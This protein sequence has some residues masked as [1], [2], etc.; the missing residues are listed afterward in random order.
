MATTISSSSF[1][2]LGQDLRYGLRLL[3]RD[4]G[5]TLIAVL[6]IALGVGA[7]TT[8]FSVT[9]SLLLKPLP[10]PDADRLV[11]LSETRQGRSARIPGTLLNGTYLAFADRPTTIDA[12]GGCRCGTA[13]TMSRGG[14]PGRL[15]IP[16]TTPGLFGLLRA[17]PPMGRLVAGD[18][19]G[20]RTA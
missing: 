2:G 10:W 20:C 4:P 3:R 15:Q 14:D 17:R 16:P 9:Y 7:A 6:T 18:E 11:R 12:I 19:G 5:F 13:M 1:G 8:L